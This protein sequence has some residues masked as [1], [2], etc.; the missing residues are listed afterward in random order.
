MVPIGTVAQLKSNTIPYRVPRYNLFPAAEVQG[1]AAP[2][3]ASGTALASHGG[4]RAPGAAE[5][6]RL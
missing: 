4:A 6:H 3:V 2:G 5:G 1:V